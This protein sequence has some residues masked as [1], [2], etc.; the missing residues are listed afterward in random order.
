MF[1]GIVTIE[2]PWLSNV[3][4]NVK[5]WGLLGQPAHCISTG[6]KFQKTP[7]IEAMES[8]WLPSIPTQLV[9]VK[10]IRITSSGIQQFYD[11]V[12]KNSGGGAS[13]GWG[14]FTISGSS[15][16]ASSNTET[17]CYMDNGWLVIN[18]AQL[19]GYV[20]EI[21]PPSPTVAM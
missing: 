18:G 10:D 3:L 1:Y 11:Y 15:S 9:I 19:I 17:S 4:L 5:G 13:F 16:W 12:Q 8:L 14:P 21:T 7:A 2:R 20:L 6:E